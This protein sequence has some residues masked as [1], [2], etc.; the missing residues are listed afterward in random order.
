VLSPEQARDA[1]SK[2]LAQARLGGDPAALRTTARNDISV[3]DLCDN[4]LA[5]GCALKKASTIV[6]DR[7]RIEAHIKPLLGH[8][9]VR[10][11]VPRD[12]EKFL[13]DVAAGKSAKDRKTKKQGR[14]LVRGGKGAATRTVRL[15]GGMFTWAVKQGLRSDNPC[16]GVEKFPDNAGERYL[17]TDEFGRLGDAIRLAETAGVPFREST[18]K[19]AAK[20]GKVTIDQHAAAAL[21]L[22]LFTGCRVSEILN[23]RWA[24]ADLERGLLFLPDSK[25]GRKTIV[26]SGAAQAVLEGLPRFGQYV[27]ASESAGQP[28]ERPRHDLKRPWALVRRQAGLEGV[29]LHDLRHS[30]ASVGAGSG[31]GLPVVGKLLGHSQAQTTARY[32]HVDAE[33]A[34]RAA[35]VIGRYIQDAMKGKRDG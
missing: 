14:S 13:V 19:H 21:R 9:K 11:V 23:L 27:V 6:T 10:D 29:R 17:T 20:R 15:L 25:T 28:N 34:R 35:D 18:N 8:R 32:A 5:E 33:P 30:F 1:A 7:S 22:L 24:E 12:I 3:S 26:L 2:L 16:I 31:L 4:Y